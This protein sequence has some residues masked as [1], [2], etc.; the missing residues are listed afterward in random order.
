MDLP[1]PPANLFS[2]LWL[3]HKLW[4]LNILSLSNC[5]QQELFPK[6]KIFAV[7]L[8][9]GCLRYSPHRFIKVDSLNVLSR[10]RSSWYLKYNKYHFFVQTNTLNKD[11]EWDR[12]GQSGLWLVP[13]PWGSSVQNMSEWMADGY[14]KVQVRGQSPHPPFC[15]LKMQCLLLATR[16]GGWEIKL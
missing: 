8:L 1:P 13:I 6:C 5:K 12:A 4:F 7:C 14:M 3:I 2:G 10:V 15:Q 16:V 11:T 9:S